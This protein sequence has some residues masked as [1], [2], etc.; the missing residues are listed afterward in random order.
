MLT[1]YTICL[2]NE[3]KGSV[4]YYGSLLISK[5]KDLS[6]R[7]KPTNHQSNGPSVAITKKIFK[8]HFIFIKERSI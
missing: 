5:Q 7:I 8:S 2:G 4:T 3:I 1:N 6:R